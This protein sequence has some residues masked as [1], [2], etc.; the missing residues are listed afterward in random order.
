MMTIIIIFFIIFTSFLFVHLF[1]VVSAPLLPL[2]VNRASWTK[3]R[4]EKKHIRI[5][6]HHTEKVKVFS[7]K[8]PPIKVVNVTK[9]LQQY[10]SFVRRS[11]IIAAVESSVPIK[12]SL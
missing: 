12:H 9:R 5:L 7:N 10:F 6:L 3:T 2:G 4:K 8:N 1:A 11:I